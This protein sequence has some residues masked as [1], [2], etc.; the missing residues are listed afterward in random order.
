[1]RGQS[2]KSARA[3]KPSGPAHSRPTLCHEGAC[4][5][6]A[7]PLLYD[8]VALHL[9]QCEKLL[10]YGKLAT[11]SGIKH[12]FASASPRGG[13]AGGQWG[14]LSWKLLYDSQSYLCQGRA[15]ASA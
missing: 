10:R 3:K 12:I 14:L 7:V 4:I 9:G 5:F 1:M 13:W 15:G 6:L 11:S 2:I 8:A